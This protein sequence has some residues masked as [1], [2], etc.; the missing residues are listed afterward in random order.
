M[1]KI[2]RRVISFTL[3]FALLFGLFPPVELDLGN[4]LKI[5]LDDLNLGLATPVSAATTLNTGIEGLGAS[6]EYKSGSGYK[7]ENGSVTLGDKA[8]TIKATGGILNQTRIVLTLT[9]NLGEEATLKYSYSTS[10]GTVSGAA[11]STVLASGASHTITFYN[12]RN[13]TG[14]L[15]ITDIQFFSNEAAD[16][17]ITFKAPTNGSYTVGGTAITADTNLSYPVGTEV[18]LVATPAANYEFLGWHNGTEYVSFDASYTYTVIE[19]A[20][21]TPQFVS[22]SSPKFGLGT[23]TSGVEWEGQNFIVYKLGTEVPYYNVQVTQRFDNFNDAA[24]CA[25]GSSSKKYIVLLDN[26]E[27]SAGTYTVPSGV[28]L[29]IPFDS[30]N[31]L[32]KDLAWNTSSYTPP[33]AYRTLTLKEGAKLVINGEVSV[34]GQ[35]QRTIAGQMNGS[36][37]SGPQ[38]FIETKSGSEITVNSGGSLYAWGYITGGGKV[39]ANKGAKVYELFQIGDFRGGTQSTSSEM[40][41]NK[42][43][44]LSQ[45]YVQ[46]IEVELTIHA[47]ATEYACTTVFMS[48]AAFCSAVAFIGSSGCMFNMSSGYVTKKYD[49]GNDRLILTASGTVSVDPIEMPVGG[50][51]INSKNFV[52]PITNTFTVNIK[53]GSVTLNQNMALLPGSE[54]IVESGATCKIGSGKSIYV[55][56]SDIYNNAYDNTEY[57]TWVG[58]YCWGN[59]SAN[60]SSDGQ[61]N[62]KFVPL[63]YAPGRDGTATT[64]TYAQLRAAQVAKLTDSPFDDAKITVAGTVDATAGYIYTTQGGATVTGV[65]GAIVKLNPGTPTSTKL[66]LQNI[67]G[68]TDKYVNIPVTAPVL[69]NADGTY[70]ETAKGDPNGYQYVDGKWECYK[71]TDTCTGHTPG[72]AA[73]CTTA[74]NCTVCGAEIVP[75]LSHAYTNGVCDVCQ[76]KQTFEVKFNGANVNFD[77]ATTVEYG[78]AYQVKISLPP[79]YVLNANHTLGKINVTVNHNQVEY[80]F[81]SKT[82]IISIAENVITGPVAIYVNVV[83]SHSNT[84]ETW[85]YDETSHWKKCDCEQAE[86]QKENHSYDNDCDKTCNV[87]GATR[88]I[89]HTYK[90]VVTAPTCTEA[91]YTTYTCACGDTYKADEVAATGHTEETIP[92]KAAT[93]TETG[94]TDG[95]KCA[96]CGTTTVARTEIPATGHTNG[97]P[98]REEVVDATCEVAG[99]YDEVV[100]CTVCNAEISRVNKA[101]EALG[102]KWADTTYTW[103]ENGKQ[104]TAKHV[105]EID[106][107][108]E[109]TETVAASGEETTPATCTVNGWTTYTANFEAAWAADQTQEKQDIPALGHKDENKDHKC[110]ECGETTSTC[111]D[112]N[113]KDHV[114]DYEGCKATMGEHADGDDNNHLCDYCEGDVGETCYDNNKD[115]KCDECGEPTSTCVDENPKDHVCDYEGCKATMGEHADGE[116]DNDHVCDYCGGEV[117]G[118]A[119]NGGIANCTEDAVCVE[120]GYHYIP[121]LGHRFTDDKD[122]DCDFCNY[123]RAAY[124]GNTNYVILDEALTAAQEGDTIVVLK[125][126]IIENDVTWDLTGKT[127]DVQY[128]NQ[129]DYAL[130]VRGNLTI[131][132]G[133]FNF[134]NIYGIGVTASGKLTIDGGNFSTLADYYLIGNWGTTTINGGEFNAVYCNVNGFGGTTEIK[135]GTFNIT[136]KEDGSDV[137]GAVAVSGGDFSTDVTVYCVDG[138]HTVANAEDRYIPATHEFSAEWTTDETNHWRECACGAIS[139]LGAHSYTDNFD[140]NCDCG[141]VNPNFTPVVAMIGEVKYASFAEAVADAKDGE[142]IVLYADVTLTEKLTVVTKQIWAFGEYTVT[143]CAVDGNYG[144]IVKGDLTIESGNFVINGWYGIG[145][146]GELTIN[147]GEFK[148]AGANDY[149]IGSWGTTTITGG[150]FVGDYCNVNG[151]AG[152]LNISGGEFKVTNTDTEYPASDVFAEDGV[153]TI[154]GG[155]FSTDVT[156]YCADG[157]HTVKS[158]DVYVYGKH[159]LTHKINAKE[160]TLNEEGYTGDTECTDCGRII[161]YGTTIPVKT[162]AEAEVDGFKYATLAEA[163]EAAKNTGKTIVLLKDI[164]LVEKL[165]VEG[166]QTWNLN[167]YTLKIAS[168]PS[169][170]GLV[171]KGDLTVEGGSFIIEGMYGIGVTGKLTVNGGEFKVEG[172]NDYL[173]GNWGTT[174]INGGSFEGQYCCVNN[175]GGT[176]TI[177]GGT[178]KTAKIDASGYYDSC[179]LFADSGLTVNGGTFSKDVTEYCAEGYHTVKDE[180]GNYIYGKHRY[181]NLQVYTFCEEYGYIEITCPDCGNTYDSRTDAE[182][183]KYL[184]DMPFFNLNPKDHIYD[185]DFDAICNRDNCGHE[186]EAKTLV[187]MIG[188]K[189]YDNL[190]DAVAA[191]KDGET[192]VLYTDVTLTEKLTV[193]TT[194]IWEF[195]KYT[196]TLANGDENYSLVVKGDLTIKSGKIVAN[197]WYG[198]GVTGKLT[199]DGGEFKVEGNNDYLIGNWGTT[200]INGGSFEGQYCCVNNFVGTT[201]VNGGSFKTEEKDATGEYDS[202]DLF[203]DS[204][205]TVNGGTFSKDVTEYCAEGYHTVKSGDVYVY[206]A[207]IFDATTNKCECGLQNVFVDCYGDIKYSVYKNTV[208][209]KYGLACKAVFLEDGKYVEI[210]ATPNDDGTYSFTAPAGVTNIVIVVIGDADGNGELTINDKNLLDAYLAGTKTLSDI[211][212]F[213]ADVNGNGAIN[214]IDRILLARALM[215]GNEAIYKPFAWNTGKGA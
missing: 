44:P 45:Y 130:K 173:I 8:I 133:S 91:G 127:L 165:T 158:G 147:G 55:Y 64:F 123:S 39:T 163:M 57:P 174:T 80:I 106:A 138:Y 20:T 84:D 87:C 144:V 139:E 115:H 148:V 170:Y 208:T 107:S 46:N 12:S 160:A 101:I 155:T 19:D 111:V 15:Y 71:A 10:K 52:L 201:T 125:Q 152:T 112:E 96:V 35:H 63:I 31:T 72:A 76:D 36:S 195:G 2:L 92:G 81:D 53:S 183:Q 74:Q 95:K 82:G 18:A 79:C 113:P 109:E 104:C 28:T 132:G 114:C 22:S 122:T 38:G 77:G 94:L 137:F 67:N 69:K 203:A 100:Y 151:F 126:I 209:V 73:T 13:T 4:G 43:F 102:H 9:N 146:T 86:L 142:T 190:A 135:G 154:T 197:G 181:A 166:T 54:I 184:V 6:W 192:I 3:T 175:F 108:H 136:D 29:L 191:A 47:G 11:N 199:V 75:V 188:D 16:P 17:T 177:N 41:S 214:S 140:E 70:L 150:K 58:T 21:L 145:V 156:D 196:V 83:Q 213:A 212:I 179:D 85:Q 34:S 26:V 131:K 78:K 62:V 98:V 33:T 172:N 141:Y 65:N 159:A 168:V 89:T 162:G 56:D 169:N 88:E 27:L 143:T 207:H 119:H 93:C 205:L 134:A 124:I 1:K 202:C 189:K 50:S 30:S 23:V 128:S 51:S 14:Y 178:F 116:D 32:Y 90:S 117:E 118:E 210:L 211:Q 180:N 48:S 161:A 182:A 60:P 5:N 40:E 206:G 186:R 187:A 103:T 25:A 120:C 24:T 59:A 49:G 149:L 121:A 68:D 215:S 129:N 153:A 193:E 42:V 176:T 164:D 105:C 66:M 194:Q 61:Q 99:S 185:D 97:D 37:P 200:T 7:A 198:I 157:Y 167:G 204:G 171:V 110:D